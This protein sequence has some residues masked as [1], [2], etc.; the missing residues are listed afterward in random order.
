MATLAAWAD[1]FPSRL[2][3]CRSSVYVFPSMSMASAR[4]KA[5]ADQSESKV[6]RQL[7]LLDPFETLYLGRLAFGP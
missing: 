5:T 1:I 6:T 2:T 4:M 3:C 7:P